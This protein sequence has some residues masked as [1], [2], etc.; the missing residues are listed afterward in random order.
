MRQIFVNLPVKHLEKSKAFWSSLGFGFDAR[1]TN[2]DG[3]CLVIE[4]DRIYR[5]IVST[6]LR[7]IQAESKTRK[8]S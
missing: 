5:K 1:F 3:A 2:Q 7:R 4:K 8:P 6:F